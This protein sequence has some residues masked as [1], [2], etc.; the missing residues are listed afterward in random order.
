MSTA[1]DQL[2]E[3]VREANQE[4][5]VAAPSALLAVIATR[6]DPIKALADW[7]RAN[8]FFAAFDGEFSFI[9]RVRHT[10]LPMPAT[11][12]SRYASLIR[13]LI[14]ELR[15]WSASADDSSAQRT[16]SIAD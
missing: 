9:N 3:A 12:L 16:A 13:W 7:D 8:E 5:E 11:E 2:A 6:E 15:Q 14:R 10:K 1:S 4:G